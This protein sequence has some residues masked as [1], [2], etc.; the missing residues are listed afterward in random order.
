MKLFLAQ[1]LMKNSPSTKQTVRGKS[2]LILSAPSGL[3]GLFQGK[4]TDSAMRRAL[5]ME[6]TNHSSQTFAS[7]TAHF[8]LQT[9]RKAG[10]RDKTAQLAELHWCCGPLGK[11]R[12]PHFLFHVSGVAC[13]WLSWSLL[14]LPRHQKESRDGRKKKDLLM[15]FAIRNTWEKSSCTVI[16]FHNV[17]GEHLKCIKSACLPEWLFLLPA[18]WLVRK[19]K[20]GRGRERSFLKHYLLC[21]ADLF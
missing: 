4:I 12:G 6:T 10:S 5:Q 18:R 16:T 9:S 2:M 1:M 13:G 15:G 20:G 7:G 17:I 21:E 3:Q 14:P 11:L 8:S 19:K